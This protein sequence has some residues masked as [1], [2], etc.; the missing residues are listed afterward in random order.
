MKGF[1]SQK[2][3]K[4]KLR[5]E[6]GFTVEAASEAVEGLPKRL[7]GKR[8]KVK[9]VDVLRLIEE[10]TKP[11]VVVWEATKKIRPLSAKRKAQIRAAAA[12]L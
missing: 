12:G 10:A 6:A 11:T 8:E 5:R 7:F 4:L 1:I 3:A 2:Q 9:G